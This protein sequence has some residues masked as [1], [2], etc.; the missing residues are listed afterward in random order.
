MIAD[1]PRANRLLMATAWLAL[2]IF[3]AIR[4]GIML[5]IQTVSPGM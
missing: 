5:F 1:V 2:L 4:L 3:G